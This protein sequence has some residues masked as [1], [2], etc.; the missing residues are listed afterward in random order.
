MCFGEALCVRDDNLTVS[1]MQ[2]RWAIDS[3]KVARPAMDGTHKFVF[4]EADVDALRHYF[5]GRQRPHNLEL[6][7]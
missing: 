3:G 7:A 2:L 6:A 4:G 1:I 5:Q